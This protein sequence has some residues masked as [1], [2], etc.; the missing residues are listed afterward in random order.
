M[1][2]ARLCVNCHE[3][4]AWDAIICPSCATPTN[5]DQKVAIRRAEQKRAWRLALALAIVIA[6][7]VY[8]IRSLLL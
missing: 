1:S 4:L 5:S 6:L 7:V 2:P 3:E 8:L